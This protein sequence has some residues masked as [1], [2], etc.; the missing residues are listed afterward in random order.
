[1]SDS[2]LVQ[3]AFILVLTALCLSLVVVAQI[4]HSHWAAYMIAPKEVATFIDTV[5]FS[6]QENESYD[7]DV[8]KVQRLEDK[9]R[10]GQLLREIQKNGDDLREELNSLLISES[11]ATLKSSTR[12]LWASKRPQLDD[13]VRRLDLLRMRFLVVYLG[14]I[15]SIA[16]K[17]PPPAPP[18]PRDPEKLPG[19][20]TPT[21]PSKPPLSKS[22]T[23]YMPKR[24]PVRRLTT[25]A[26][27]HHENVAVSGRNGWAGVVEELQTSPRMHQRH[28]SIERAMSMSPS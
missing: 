1:M 17:Q 28:A 22:M 6:I 11:G 15:S 19:F 27:G 3:W 21:R 23:D 4:V 16:D 2:G 24:P 5:D 25:Q 20:T 26:I 10:L 13:R 8:A 12:L 18:L 7:R 14:I 9:I